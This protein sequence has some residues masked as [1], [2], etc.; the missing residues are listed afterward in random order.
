M[1]GSPGG[2][3][4]SSLS[5]RRTAIDEIHTS[6]DSLASRALAE[7]DIEPFSLAFLRHSDN[8]TYKVETPGSDAFL[9]RLHVPVT[10]AMG[11]HGADFDAVYSELLWL[12]ALSEDTELVLQEPVRNR[13]G[14]LVT[15]VPTGDGNTAINCSLLR[16]VDGQPYHRDLECERT[17]RQIGVILATLHRHAS[18]WEI[19]PGFKRPVRDI[20]YFEGVLRGLQPALDD[21]RIAAHDF[22]VYETSIGLLTDMMRSLEESCESYGIM[23]ADTHKGNML[24]YEGEIYEGEIRLIDFGFCAFGN[25]MF[26]LG[27]GLGDME[28]HL[29][30]ACL[31]GYQSV[32]ALPDGYQRL[33]EGFFV[34][35]I[36]G[37]FS[38][39]VANPR[40]QELLARKVPQIARDNAAKF[41]R[42]ESFWFP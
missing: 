25:Y 42:A 39:W 7:Y 9:L 30:R 20:P 21:G 11:A 32:R 40:A 12:E 35:S 38:F 4:P 16:W 26:D 18:R 10:N 37:T 33:T 23:H 17:A 19:P 2:C 41:N 6:F 29:Q 36:V 15:Q 24:Y 22:G 13:A 28:E 27:I 34:G 14:A 3:G 1:L 5:A 31:D 8:V